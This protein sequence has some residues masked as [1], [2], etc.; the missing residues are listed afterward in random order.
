MTGMRVLAAAALLAFVGALAVAGLVFAGWYNVAASEPHLRTTRAFLTFVTRRSVEVR[1]KDIRAPD[2][3]AAELIR[4]GAPHYAE[5]CAACHGAPGKEP[6]ELA[7]GLTPPPPDLGKA[8]GHWSA[9][10]LFWIIKNGIRMTGMPAWGVTHSDEELW[11]LVAF[12]SRLS[13][14]SPQE[15]E[16]LIE[17][18][19]QRHHH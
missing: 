13:R 2:V 1:A 14:M 10:E 15:Y 12:V 4:R 5:N 3:T 8:A 7:K 17:Q 6:E 16:A 11:A 19:R 18:A 9:P